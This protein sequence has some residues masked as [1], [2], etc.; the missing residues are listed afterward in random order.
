MGIETNEISVNAKGGTEMMVER[1]K[2]IN[3][4]LLD[5]FQI[6]PS[7]VRN[8]DDSKR[9]IYWAHDLPNDPE[10]QHLKNGGWQK[11]NKLVFVSHWQ[12]QLYINYFGIPWSKTQ[13]LQNAI[14]PVNI[15]KSYIEEKFEML[16]NDR[17]N[18]IYHTTPHRGLR[19]LVPVFEQLA[20]KHPEIHLDV[21]SSFE[22]YGWGQRDEEFKDVFRKILDHPQMSYYGSKPN[23]VVKEALKKAHVF[24]YPSIWPETSCIALME[25][26]SAGCICVHPDFAALPETAANLTNMYTWIEDENKHKNAF[27]SIMDYTIH[28]L[29]K[30]KFQSIVHLQKLYVDTFYDWNLRKNQWENFLR[31][32][33]DEP[34]FPVENNVGPDAFIY[35][36]N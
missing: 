33:M 13:V 1:L 20:E 11:F 12:Q 16:E 4:G 6:I 3:P 8:L 24:A 14:E 34:I 30:K 2:T 10:S 26:M 15:D 28:S 22:I 7:R 27:Y 19:L 32:L 29:K 18:L 31:N 21:Y 35:R 9:R 17:I 25:A 36:T 5:Q 23:A